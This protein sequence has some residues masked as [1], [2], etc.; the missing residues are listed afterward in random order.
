LVYEKSGI[1]ELRTAL[2]QLT[3][4]WRKIKRHA[5][6]EGKARQRVID[7]TLKASR[8]SQI[9]VKDAAYQVME[10][11]YLKA[12]NDGALPAN[13]RQIMYAARPMIIELTGKDTPWSDSRR[14]TSGLL[15]EF[16]DDHP[17]LAADW[18]VVFDARGH[19]HEPHNSTQVDLGTLGVR[20]YV[21]KWQDPTVHSLTEQVSEINFLSTHGPIGRYKFVLFIEKEGFM[22]LLRTARVAER[23][24]LAIMS[25][26][27][28]SN[29]AARKLIE[30]LTKR[31]VTILV[32]HD[33]DKSGFTILHTLFNGTKRYTFS[34]EPRVRDMGLRLT[35]AI[36]MGL[37]SEEV[38]YDSERNPRELLLEQGA[39][40]EEA[41]FMVQSGNPKNWRGRRIELNAMT[42]EVFL[43][44]LQQKLAE[45]GVVKVIPDAETACKVY[46]QAV[47][48]HQAI[49]KLKE[50]D[51]D[52]SDVLP[53]ADLLDRL[54]AG[55]AAKPECAWDDILS[56]L[57]LEATSGSCLPTLFASTQTIAFPDYSQ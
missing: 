15:P 53:P 42:A 23:Y 57:A 33:L 13:A 55:L 35:D 54:K 9:S 38:S 47:R 5:D 32:A 12:S 2:E 22:E 1:D 48:N 45:C 41:Q 14:F 29:T 34:I 44:W 31:D 39:T 16:I 8:K 19:L 56:D 11:A 40:P 46:Q 27:G 7:Q 3:R 25:T 17:E 28:M 52:L 30:Q 37:E 20:R 50:F 51:R 49:S 43:T 4:D 18:D 26:K 24:D 10:Q 21:E 6:K 36:A